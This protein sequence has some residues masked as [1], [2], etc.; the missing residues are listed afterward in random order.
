MVSQL[1]EYFSHDW[2]ADSD[3]YTCTDTCHILAA[4]KIFKYQKSEKTKI[5]STYRNLQNKL[6]TFK[7]N[8]HFVRNLQFCK[9]YTHCD[10]LNTYLRN[11][12]NLQTILPLDGQLAYDG[13]SV[14]YYQ[15]RFDTHRRICRPDGRP[16]E[17]CTPRIFAWQMI[18]HNLRIS[19]ST[20]KRIIRK[21]TKNLK[22]FR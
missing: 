16:C 8:Y 19:L 22:L 20:T 5:T 10:L 7:F 17:F 15:T 9:N 3:P 12:T 4:P 13:P 1:D 21:S 14:F 6:N 18:F 11:S 2:R